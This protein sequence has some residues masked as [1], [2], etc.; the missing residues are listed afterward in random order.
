MP[1]HNDIDLNAWKCPV[2]QIVTHKGRGDEFGGSA[3]TRAM[4]GN[5]Q[6]VID[7]LGDVEC[8]MSKFASSAIVF[9]MWAVLAESLPP[10]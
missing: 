8:G 4:V 9:R 3:E 5:Q 7:R 2:V 6:V 1:A 10:I